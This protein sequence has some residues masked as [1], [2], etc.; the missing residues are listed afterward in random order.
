[1]KRSILLLLLTA[2]VSVALC[3]AVPQSA[4]NYVTKARE[5]LARKDYDKV[6]EWANKYAQ[7]RTHTSLSRILLSR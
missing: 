3:G 1:M 5:A 4:N 2:V 7:E 6:M